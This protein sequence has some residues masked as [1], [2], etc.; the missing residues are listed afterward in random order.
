MKLTK[1]ITQEQFEDLKSGDKLLVEWS[2]YWTKQH[3]NGLKLYKFRKMIN[4]CEV[5]LTGLKKNHYFNYTRYINF[6]RS[7]KIKDVYLIEKED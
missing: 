5:L 4:K 7:G 6:N 2:D 1:L 3:G